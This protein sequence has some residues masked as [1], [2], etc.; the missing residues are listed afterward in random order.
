MADPEAVRALVRGA[1]DMHI[2]SSPD[3]LPRKFDDIVLAQRA[4]EAGMAG[5]VI[6]NHYVGTADRATLICRMFPGLQVF[7]GLALNNSVGGLNPLAVDIAGRLGAKVV[8]LPTVDNANELANIGGQRDES[9][10]PYW[11]TIA[12]EMR[13]NGIAGEPLRVTDG[14]GKV[15]DA[16]RRCLEVIGQRDMVLATGHIGPEEMEPVVKA[17]VEAKVQRIVITHPEFPTTFLNLDQQRKLA[18]HGV[19]F[20]RCFTTWHT[21]KVPWE[22][23]VSNIRRI[24]PA[25]TILSTDLGQSTAPWVEE[26][27]GIY[28]GR[29]LDAGFM[30]AEVEAM[31]QRNAGQVL[32]TLVSASA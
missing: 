7:G 1:Y 28:I 30:E 13:A 6:K 14:H 27:L 8:W 3:V 4:L 11:M 19:F 12:R 17:A 10:L 29:L 15:T 16:T 21:N 24:G 5:F 32:G 22:T 20:E 9:K 31:A 26:G 18:R 2:H 25:S 23:V